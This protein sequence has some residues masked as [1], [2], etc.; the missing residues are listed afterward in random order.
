MLATPGNIDAIKAQFVQQQAP[1]V[2]SEAGVVSAN[3][4]GTVKE[5]S[6][7]APALYPFPD[8]GNLLAWVVNVEQP[9]VFIILV[10]REPDITKEP[11]PGV[12]ATCRQAEAAQLI[13]DGVNYLYQVQQQVLKAQQIV[14][15]AP[16]A[17]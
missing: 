13:C 17:E 10:N 8:S 14:D 2:I 12:L 6:T 1:I 9:E 15:S 11:K 5:Q 16:P 4:N 3:E 7:P